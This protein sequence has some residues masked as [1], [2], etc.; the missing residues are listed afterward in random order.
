MSAIEN[1]S[2]SL[3]APRCVIVI[4]KSLDIGRAANAAAVLALTVG[5]RHPQLV[6]APL[7]DAAGEHHP[8]LI[9]FGIAVL[10][11]STEEISALRARACEA[12]CDVV[13]FPLQGQQTTNYESFREAVS[14]IDTGSLAYVGVA[15]VGEKK[16]VSKLVANLGLLK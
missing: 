13:G 14:T 10:G 15:L 11:G 12:D 9:P 2:A 1:F 3:A 4:D 5:Q 6:G 7:V 16:P 8:G